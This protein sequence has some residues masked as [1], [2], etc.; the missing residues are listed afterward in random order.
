[1]DQ[2]FTNTKPVPKSGSI[3]IPSDVSESVVAEAASC[4]G[5][6][7]RAFEGGEGLLQNSPPLTS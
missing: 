6:R 2:G 4:E 3:D 5:A 1:M 7:R